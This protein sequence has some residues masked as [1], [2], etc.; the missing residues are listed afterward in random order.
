MSNRSLR[1]DPSITINER[2]ADDLNRSRVVQLPLRERRDNISQRQTPNPGQEPASFTSRAMLA[3]TP[4][5]AP[6]KREEEDS[7]ERQFVDFLSVDDPEVSPP[8]QLM[9]SSAQRNRVGDRYSNL[10][11]T[12]SSESTEY[13]PTNFNIPDIKFTDA[14]SSFSREDDSLRSDEPK[15]KVDNF[16]KPSDYVC[17]TEKRKEDR[18][19]KETSDGEFEPDNQAFLDLEEGMSSLRSQVSRLLE[20]ENSHIFSTPPRTRTQSHDVCST[21]MTSSPLNS[22]IDDLEDYSISPIKEQTFD[23]VSN[24][25]DRAAIE[26]P[27]QK[28]LVRR[29]SIAETLT[30]FQSEGRIPPESSGALQDIMSLL[31]LEVDINDVLEY[32]E[33]RIEVNI[34]RLEQGDNVVNALAGIESDI[35]FKLLQVEAM[36]KVTKRDDDELSKIH[37]NSGTSS[38]DPE[39]RI[40]DLSGSKESE[41]IEEELMA[42]LAPIGRGGLG[43]EGGVQGLNVQIL[44]HLREISKSP[45]HFVEEEE[46]RDDVKTPVD[47]GQSGTEYNLMQN[48]INKHAPLLSPRSTAATT[49]TISSQPHIVTNRVPTVESNSASEPSIEMPARIPKS[50]VKS[51]KVSIPKDQL[52]MFFQRHLPEQDSREV[53]E[54]LGANILDI[55]DDDEPE[56]ALSGSQ[57]GQ[58]TG[59]QTFRYVYF[60]FFTF[61]GLNSS[62]SV[63]LI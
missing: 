35:E 63:H 57:M 53:M 1:L 37:G 34:D 61:C 6:I 46:D 49:N 11:K 51:Q 18:V 54:S 22:T 45:L 59:S 29:A 5:P 26:R 55:S 56:T 17:I 25:L 43:T 10:H 14:T 12:N 40:S 47:R 44:E 16:F 4:N 3:S 48:I 50:K 30:Q 41:G 36:R 27:V 8:V 13:N 2:T 42:H 7:T 28:Q 23:D 20:Q 58:K 33:K 24:I 32:L 31:D 19:E 38:I 52:M 9:K 39:V 62:A 21:P 60:K 15:T